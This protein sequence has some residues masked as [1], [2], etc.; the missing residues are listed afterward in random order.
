MAAAEAVPTA[1]DAA[2]GAWLLR[3]GLFRSRC[4]PEGRDQA[5]R[6]W[7]WGSVLSPAS[8]PSHSAL[9]KELGGWTQEGCAASSACQDAR[10]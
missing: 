9:A 1:P 6:G 7:G 8:Q 3:L 4:W 2:T 10:A 5:W